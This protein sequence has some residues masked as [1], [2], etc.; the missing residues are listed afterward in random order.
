[1]KLP[2][3]GF[4]WMIW[5]VASALGIA[6]FAGQAVAAETSGRI[7]LQ[8][9]EHGEAWYVNPQDHLRYY[10][11]RPAD[12]FEIMEEL[13]LGISDAD[14]ALIPRPNQTWDGQQDIMA[15]VRGKIVLQV[16]Q[17][18]EAWYVNPVNGKRYFLGRPADA[19]EL[20]TK[21][22]IGMTNENLWQ[23]PPDVGI[24]SLQAIGVNDSL[25]EYVEIKNDG[26]LKQK[27]DG[28][29]LSNSGSHSFT[30][31]SG[32]SLEPGQSVQV[33]TNQGDLQ[34]ASGEEVWNDLTGTALLHDNHGTFIQQFTYVDPPASYTISDIQF[35]T[36][37]PYGQWSTS[38]FDEACEEAVL[39]ML[40]AWETDHALSA[41]YV[42][43]QILQIVD[44]EKATYGFHKDTSAAY[45]K[46]TAKDYFGMDAHTSTDISI[47]KIK[48]LIATGHPVIVPVYGRGLNPHYS[49]G[50]PYYHMLLIVGYDENNFITMDPGT[51]YGNH[52]AY[53]QQTLFD[54]IHDLMSPQKLTYLGEKI[55]VVIDP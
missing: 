24:T 42:E 26:K 2:S 3:Y 8:V 36:Q 29:V 47:T 51:S 38:P 33:H 37:A 6:G 34:F 9:H 35:T 10:L 30:F 40:H 7:F 12:A 41:G 21:F 14:L 22:G 20:M 48:Q 4:S 39:V 11:G 28:W 27:L 19:F 5:L 31:P 55:M 32:T 43:D 18:G 45:T 17:H 44:W 53:N 23:I 49:A 50:G 54:A 25:D 1:M 13:G 15:R 52:Y 16:Q 46:R